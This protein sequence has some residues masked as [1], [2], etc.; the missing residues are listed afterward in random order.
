MQLLELQEQG[1]KPVLI[2]NPVKNAFKEQ[3]KKV[4]KR[5]TKMELNLQEKID[6]PDL[7]RLYNEKTVL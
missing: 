4:M 7:D 3:E 2:L 6:G 1:E 5:V